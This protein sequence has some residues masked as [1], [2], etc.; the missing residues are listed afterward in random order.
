MNWLGGLNPLALEIRAWSEYFR[1]KSDCLLQPYSTSLYNLP[2]LFPG[3][4]CIFS[5]CH[6]AITP[7]VGFSPSL[8]VVGFMGFCALESFFP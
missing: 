8:P 1:W 3:G 5:L 7:T 2:R 4:H 6:M